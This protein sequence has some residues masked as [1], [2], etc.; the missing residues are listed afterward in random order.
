MNYPDTLYVKWMEGPAD[1]PE[2]GF[3]LT[4]DF[5]VTG[6]AAYRKDKIVNEQEII[7]KERKAT[8][9]LYLKQAEKLEEL[10]SYLKGLAKTWE[11][12]SNVMMNSHDERVNE[13]GRV[14]SDCAVEL[15]AALTILTKVH[16]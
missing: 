10:E 13:G 12:T 5:P 14:M 3:W 16:P 1:E 7:K 2:S 11:D 9:D 4:C 6:G 8:A 15:R